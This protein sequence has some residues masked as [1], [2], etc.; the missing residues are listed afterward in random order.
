[1]EET[2]T[3]ASDGVKVLRLSK[4]RTQVSGPRVSTWCHRDNDITDIICNTFS[5]KHCVDHSAWCDNRKVHLCLAE[6]SRIF[7]STKLKLHNACILPIFLYSCECWAVTKRDRYTQDWFPRSMVSA[8][9]IRN[10]RYYHVWNNDV[11]WTTKQPR[12]SA[13]VQALCLSLFG[14]IAWMPNEKR[15]QEGL[16]SFPL[17]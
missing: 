1:M 4:T 14:H 11:R 6:K 13:I 9:A 10:R 17:E 3:G 12:L 16:N 8:K 15:C 2:V 7:V 5:C